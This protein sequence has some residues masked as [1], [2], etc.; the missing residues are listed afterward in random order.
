M[1]QNN[2]T[3]LSASMPLRAVSVFDVGWLFMEAVRTTYV[4]H[5]GSG[6]LICVCVC[7]C[8][9]LDGAS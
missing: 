3:H 2:I 1:F 6:I 7:V 4:I 5:Y 8:V 9:M